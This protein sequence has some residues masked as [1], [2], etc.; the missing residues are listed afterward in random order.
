MDYSD[1]T[2]ALGRI[3]G[4]ALM[5][6]HE[7]HNAIGASGATEAR[8]NAHGDMALRLDIEAE[9]AVLSTIKT[10]GLP[11]TIYS[12]EHGIVQLGPEPSSY[13]GV[14]DGLDGSS[15]YKRAPGKGGYGT[16]LALY[17]GK[18]PRYRDYLAAGIID[19]GSGDLHLVAR[20]R[21]VSTILSDGTS[22]AT[23]TSGAQSL[24]RGARYFVD[25]YFPVNRKIFEKP[26]ADY[27]PQCLGSTAMHYAALITGKADLVLECTRKGNLELA[28]AYGL[29]KAAG[30]AII[31]LDGADIGEQFFRSFG[32]R[33][34]VPTIA[35]ATPQLAL[36]TLKHLAGHS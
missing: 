20:G 21:E 29:V 33:S 30:G 23:K 1:Y 17:D 7:L 24:R 18:K 22:R 26:L 32:Q 6:T 11:I 31:T 25:T 8:R 34:H 19:H 13:T 10:A 12:E 2:D 28:V 4:T 16:M 35:A 36:A 3:V 9:G 27:A 5:K 15:V 14:L